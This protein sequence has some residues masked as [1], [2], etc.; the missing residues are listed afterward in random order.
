MI[1]KDILKA[2]AMLST[3]DKR[4][5]DL[6]RYYSIISFLL[7]SI[8]ICGISLGEVRTYRQI[9]DVAAKENGSVAQSEKNEDLFEYSFSINRTK[10]T[11]TRTS[12]RRLDKKTGEKDNTVYTI[13]QKQKLLGS[14]SGNG[15]KVLIAVRKDGGEIIELGHRFAF[16]MRSSSFS[17]VITG[18]YQ[19][20][21]DKD[22]KKLCPKKSKPAAK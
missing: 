5:I 10:N 1:L 21:Y 12:V 14:E 16:T 19:R 20:A 2:S 7:C 18:I 8:V 22:R 13:M 15:G 11:I 9:K 17:Q 4:S 6:K 3:A